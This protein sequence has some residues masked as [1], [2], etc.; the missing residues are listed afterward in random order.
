MTVIPIKAFHDNYIWALFNESQPVFDCVDPGDAKPVLDHAAQNQLNLRAILLT[1]H[2]HDHIGGVERLMTQ[3][4]RCRIYG[5]KSLCMPWITD[6]MT[7]KNIFQLGDLLFHVI[8]NP[9]H[10]ANHISYYVPKENLLFCGDALFS[11]GCGRVFDGTIEQLHHSLYKINQLP[12]TTRLFCAHEYT[13]SNLKFAQ[14]VE[15]NNAS[16]TKRLLHLMAHPNCCTLPSTLGTEQAINPFLRTEQP[17]VIQYALKHG[18]I[19]T[20]SFEVFKTIRM[21]KDAFC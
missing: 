14:T 10:T 7:E 16:I 1:H 12:K 11:A 5:P 21:M 9:G 6:P 3:F 8:E 18:A 13:L 17:D 15:P 2:H 20:T 19:N 4:P